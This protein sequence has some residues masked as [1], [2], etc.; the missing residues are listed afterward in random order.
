MT[1]MRAGDEARAIREAMTAAPASLTVRAGGTMTVRVGAV[2]R[3]SGVGEIVARCRARDNRDLIAVGRVVAEARRRPPADNNYPVAVTIPER[4]PT[5][6]WEVHRIVLTDHDGNRRTYTAGRDF[7]P[8]VFQVV[9]REGI[10]STP[11]RLL[12]VQVAGET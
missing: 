12:G 6:L 1:W 4:A 9:S 3:Q 10:D 11:P 8:I 5:G 2:D 7:A